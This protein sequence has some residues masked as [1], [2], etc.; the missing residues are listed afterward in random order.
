LFVLFVAL[1]VIADVM[2][3][4]NNN[5]HSAYNPWNALMIITAI[6]FLI[7]LAGLTIAL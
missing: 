5:S 3:S 2:D 1:F 4:F 6:C 7:G